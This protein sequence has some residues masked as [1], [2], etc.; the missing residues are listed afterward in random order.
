MGTRL[1]FLFLLLLGC[2]DTER[3]NVV[4]D[5]RYNFVEVENQMFYINKVSI[6]NSL[7]QILY[8][9]KLQDDGVG[10]SKVF[11]FQNVNYYLESGSLEKV[12]NEVGKKYIQ[13]ELQ[14]RD[15]QRVELFES[16]FD[17]DY[18]GERSISPIK[19]PFP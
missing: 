15:K 6:L 8:E 3:Q 7:A 14:S 4:I 10:A 17:L 5:Y 2:R 12:K 19:E 16:I 9:L 11:L 18:Q 1:C 13:V